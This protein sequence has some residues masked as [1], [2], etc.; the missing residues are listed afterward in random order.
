MGAQRLGC[1]LGLGVGRVKVGPFIAEEVIPAHPTGV[2]IEP[3]GSGRQSRVFAVALCVVGLI[4]DAQR[5]GCHLGL[6][7]SRVQVGPFIAEEVVP[8]HPADVGVD[9]L[10]FVWQPRVFAVALCVVGLILDAQRLGCR[11]GLGV[12]IKILLGWHRRQ[13]LVNRSWESSACCKRSRS[14]RSRR[15]WRICVVVGCV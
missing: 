12:G 3:T 8:V 2:G 13:S 1:R 14:S 11:L 15:L 10:G 4:L 6:G 7:V 9:L 5:L